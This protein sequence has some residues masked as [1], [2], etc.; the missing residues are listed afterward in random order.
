MI[1]WVASERALAAL[2]ILACVY[3]VGSY[4]LFLHRVDRFRQA[5]PDEAIAYALC[6]RRKS[7]PA[8]TGRWF[9]KS[10]RRR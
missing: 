4:S 8:R 2:V 10:L 1:G 3:S 9:S 7:I 6:L 5:H